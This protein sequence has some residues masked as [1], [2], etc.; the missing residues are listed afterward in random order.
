[1]IQSM[2][3]YGAASLTSDNYRISVELKSLNSKFMEVNLKLPRSYM[4]EELLVRNLLTTALERGKVNV[5]LSVEVLNPDKHKLRIN[6]PLLK[7][8]ARDLEDLRHDLGLSTGVSL[9]Y[10]LT[11]PDA[12]SPESEDGDPEEWNMIEQCFR[13]ATALL[14]ESRASEGAALAEDLRKCNESIGH[15]LAEVRKL[16]PARYEAM[17]SR[18]ENVAADLHDRVGNDAN[19]FEQELIFYMEKLDINE[20]MVRLEQH[21]NYFG[22]ALIETASN[23][24]K[25][26]FISQEMGREINTIG[27]KANDAT[28]QILVVQMKEDLERIKE[29][30]L[31]IV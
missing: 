24:K 23:G 25:L 16:L 13:D 18:I 27:S 10:L 17:R 4:Q 7:A 2:T 21:V 31:N 12:M 1:M 14:N 6:R 26:G 8:Y 28:I 30:V 5:S 29:Q 15:N 11:L 9:E 20:E 22:Q 3:G 19:R